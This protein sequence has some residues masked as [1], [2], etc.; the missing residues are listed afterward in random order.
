MPKARTTD[1]S[2]PAG[3]GRPSWH[4]GTGLARGTRGIGVAALALSAYATPAMA[5]SLGEVPSSLIAAVLVGGFIGAMV[6]LLITRARISSLMR[7]AVEL[8]DGTELLLRDGRAALLYWNIV[9]GELSWSES[10]FAMIGRKLPDGRM[11]YRDMR[12]LLH[13][14]DDL[15]QIID[16]HI[17][18][19]AGEVRTCFRLRGAE[20]GAW[21]WF[22]LRGR[23]RRRGE[24]APPILVAVVTD[25]VR[26]GRRVVARPSSRFAR[27][28][29]PCAHCVGAGKAW[30][31]AWDNIWHW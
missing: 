21:L 14:N 19:G 13:P 17:R 26:D 3:F 8:R 1:C 27:N 25:V 12:E 22:D 6:C 16:E 2:A 20:P 7:S 18:N 29:A 11:P 28:V 10:F 24:G 23:I 4:A 15:Y 30:M 31:E 5:F 9:K